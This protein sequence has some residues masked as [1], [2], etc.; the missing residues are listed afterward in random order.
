MKKLILILFLTPMWFACQE[1]DEPETD[2]V[3]DSL[4]DET[5][6]LSGINAEQA[7]ALDSFFRA[8][9]DIQANLD[10]I[11]E[12]EKIIAKDTA[13]G[14]VAS[15][16][17]K[18]TADIQSIYDLMVLNKQ[19]LA[20][21]KKNLKDADLQIASMQTTIDQLNATLITREAEIVVLKDDL[22]KKNLEL[23]NLSMNYTEL[24]QEADAKTEQLNTAYYAFGSKKE[25]LAQGVIAEE[26][27]VIGLGKSVKLS[28]TPNTEYFTQID[29]T[30]V[31]EIPLSSKE[32]QVISTHPA[33]SYRI[34][35]AD[36][37]ADKLVI[38]NPSQFWSVSKYLVVVVK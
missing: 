25:L 36:D 16:K 35:G 22:E 38:T 19:R 37:R 9:N 29:V 3:K 1:N 17:D 31:S 26:G 27:G 5:N 28:T 4:T 23:S 12:K 15:R 11:R 24:Q 13:G 34:E 20:S 7:A 33:G 32:A 6:R 2:P 14:D 8:M 30:K 21:A 18:I 10:A